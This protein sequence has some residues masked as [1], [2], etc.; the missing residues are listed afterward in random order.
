M[1]VVGDG[2]LFEVRADPRVTGVGRLLRRHSL[3]ELLRAARRAGGR[4][5]PGRT[6][7]RL[8][9]RPVLAEPGR[10]GLWQVS[11][12]P[13]WDDSVRVDVRSARSGLWRTTA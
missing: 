8:V 6:A 4:A 13:F 5:V 12:R 1:S 3:D 10:T 9:P 2:V 11:G 7:A